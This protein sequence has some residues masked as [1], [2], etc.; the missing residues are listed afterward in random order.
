VKSIVLVLSTVSLEMPFELP[1]VEE[2]L[3]VLIG[4]LEQLKKPGCTKAKF[5]G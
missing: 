1:L 2:A 4:A 3:K 5:R